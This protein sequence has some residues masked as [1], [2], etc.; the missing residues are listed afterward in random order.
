MQSGQSRQKLR[1]QL[2]VFC[3][4][5]VDQHSNNQR[6]CL[7]N[8]LILKNMKIFQYTG[9]EKYLTIHFLCTTTSP[10]LYQGCHKSLSTKFPVFSQCFHWRLHHFPRVMGKNH[11]CSNNSECYYPLVYIPTKKYKSWDILYY[12]I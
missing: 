10:V 3:L 4:P 8:N 9:I 6:N 2:Q 1:I 7:T 5:L 12:I 11:H